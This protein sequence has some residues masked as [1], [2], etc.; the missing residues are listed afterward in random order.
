MKFD[1]KTNFCGKYN[2]NPLMLDRFFVW[3]DV[4]ELKSIFI[5][6]LAPCTE[7]RNVLGAAYWLVERRCLELDV[8]WNLIIWRRGI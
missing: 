8:A 7:W 1:C 5:L 2:F 4:F 6:V 3:V